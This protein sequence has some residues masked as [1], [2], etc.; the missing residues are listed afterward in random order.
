[1]QTVHE[2]YSHRR[3]PY[4]AAGS[5][6]YEDWCGRHAQCPNSDAGFVASD[7]VRLLKLLIAQL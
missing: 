7:L 4:A 6:N 2:A 3:F 1:M 5:R